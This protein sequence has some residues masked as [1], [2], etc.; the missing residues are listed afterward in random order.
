MNQESEQAIDHLRKGNVILYPT[1]T[2]WGL[3]CDPSNQEAV[4]RI[5]DIKKRPPSLPLIVI[6]DSIQML[7]T[8]VPRIHP[9]LEEILYYNIRPLTLIYENIKKEFA[10]GVPA[11]DGS[12]AIRIVHDE[13]CKKIIA[14]FGGPIVSTS[15]NIH[16]Q[17]FPKSVEEIDPDIMQKAD[18]LYLPQEYKENESAVEPSLIARYCQEKKELIFLR[19]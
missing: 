5:F 3:G 14:G 15:A 11:A 2:I 6:V 8:I 12:L 17:P 19:S 4:D 1:D 18:Y 16:H 7:K 9:H 13:F 10:R